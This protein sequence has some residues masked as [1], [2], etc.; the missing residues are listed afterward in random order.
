MPKSPATPSSSSRHSKEVITEPTLRDRVLTALG[1][2]SS[3]KDREAARSGSL[4]SFFDSMTC[5]D[6]FRSDRIREIMLREPD[7]LKALNELIQMDAKGELTLENSFEV[8][9]TLN[10]KYGPSEK[11]HHRFCE[12]YFTL[13]HGARLRVKLY[14]DLND[15]LSFGFTH[16]TK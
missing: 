15:V 8:I 7:I 14:L 4:K 16:F 2:T 5:A 11:G 3:P 1:I 6:S 12:A 13:P 10:R 9:A